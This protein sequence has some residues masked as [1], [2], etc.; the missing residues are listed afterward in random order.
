MHPAPS[1]PKL[2]RFTYPFPNGRNHM[3]DPFLLESAT[4]NPII[5]AFLSQSIAANPLK[6]NST[7]RL[8]ITQAHQPYKRDFRQ[9]KAD[10]RVRIS[11]R[12]CLLFCDQ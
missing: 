1:G 6:P 8:D 5:P 2:M 11:D 12:D 10:T 7:V 9:K 4:A 3:K